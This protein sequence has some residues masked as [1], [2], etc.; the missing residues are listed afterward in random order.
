M[1]ALP[2]C[3][4]VFDK[5]NKIL[6]ADMDKIKFP[7]SIRQWRDGDYIQPLGMK[8]KRKKVSDLLVDMK[9]PVDL[10]QRVRVV[11]DA[12]GRIVCVEGMKSDQRFRIDGNTVSVLKISASE[13]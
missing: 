1:S 2:V 4:V 9:I 3:D 5:Q 8:G 6:F 12:D 11:V 7:A 13:V 10:K